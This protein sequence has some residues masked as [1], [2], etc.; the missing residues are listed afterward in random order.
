MAIGKNKRISKGRKGTKKKI[1]DPFSRKEWY[2]IKAPAAFTNRIVGKTPVNRSAGTKLASDSLK[3]R[4]ISVSLA[5]L[6]SNE[7]QAWRTIR[8]RVED[9]QGKECLTNFY[10]M[11]FTTDKLKLHVKKWQTLI[12]AHVDVKTLD[13]YGIRM[14]AIGFTKQNSPTKKTC[15]AK[16]SKVRQI[17]RKMMDIMTKEATSVELKDLVKQFIPDTIAT[18]IERECQGIYPL[19]KVFIR[20]AKIVRTPKLDPMKLLEIHG[21]GG[22][23]DTGA[24]VDR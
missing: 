12:E 1:V 17:R 21:E 7:S 5:D 14:F 2:T 24:K 4:V 11:D 6:N 8:L 16:T 13:G 23:E 20:K 15:Y 9:V 3:G 22:K 19:S 18:R 10:G